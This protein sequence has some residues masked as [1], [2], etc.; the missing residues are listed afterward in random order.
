MNKIKYN[1][2]KTIKNSNLTNINCE[3]KEK[4]NLNEN[5]QNK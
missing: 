2:N 4:G 5:E 1:I 3:K